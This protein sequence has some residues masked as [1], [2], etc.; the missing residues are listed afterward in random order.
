MNG[1]HNITH[2]CKY[3]VVF[4]PKYR[5]AVLIHGVDTDFLRIAREVC[6]ETGSELISAEAMPDHVHL[7]LRCDPQRGVHRVVKQIKGRS[8]RILRET[9]PWLRKRL[10]TLWTNAY[11]V[12]SVGAVSLETVRA[13]VEAQKGV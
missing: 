3:H 11:F 5:R 2:D 6:A 8:S 1:N 12:S 13:Y 7:L 10:P 9:H 4:T